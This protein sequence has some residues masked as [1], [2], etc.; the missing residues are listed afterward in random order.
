MRCEGFAWAGLRAAGSGS[1]T[2]MWTTCLSSGVTKAPTTI[3]TLHVE[4][5]EEAEENITEAVEEDMVLDQVRVAVSQEED[6]ELVMTGA[7]EVESM[8]RV[9]LAG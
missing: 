8:V 4:A 5:V 9:L 2:L 6:E 1:T 7:R 3:P